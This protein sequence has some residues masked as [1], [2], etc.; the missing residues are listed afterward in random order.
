MA[1]CGDE[2]VSGERESGGQRGQVQGKMPATVRSKFLD[3]AAEVHWRKST[4][5]CTLK[6]PG[7]SC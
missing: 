5:E 4:G 3:T 7:L 1:R 2:S 6:V